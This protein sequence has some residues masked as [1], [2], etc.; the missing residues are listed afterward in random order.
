M[1]EM[2]IGQVAAKA[3]IRPSALRYYESVGLLPKARRVSGQRRYGPEVLRWLVGIRFSQQAGFTLAEIRKLFHGFARSA[4]PSE[5]WGALARQKL[6]E[7]EAL[8]RQAT[9]MKRLLAEGIRCHC[10]SL[11]ECTLLRGDP[12]S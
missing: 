7:I 5:R 4:K 6:V 8:I 3:G 2:T 12:G 9:V 1:T 11:R 10:E